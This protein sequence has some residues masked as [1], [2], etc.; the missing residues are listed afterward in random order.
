[1]AVHGPLSISFS[2]SKKFCTFLAKNLHLFL[3]SGAEF[4]LSVAKNVA[5]FQTVRIL[6]FAS[7][8]W[9]DRLTIHRPKAHLSCQKCP[10]TVFVSNEDVPMD[11]LWKTDSIPT[12]I[13]WDMAERVPRLLRAIGSPLSLKPFFFSLSQESGF[14]KQSPNAFLQS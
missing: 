13:A 4:T 10:K 5:L 7:V 1:M 12:R 2:L 9:C 6:R 8:K 3:P 11:T 14:D